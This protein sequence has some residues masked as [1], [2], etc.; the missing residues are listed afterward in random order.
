MEDLPTIQLCEIKGKLDCFLQK[1]DQITH[2]FF[3]ALVIISKWP[4]VEFSH[5]TQSWQ[6]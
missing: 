4:P 5:N 1:T 6:C 2:Y 3:C